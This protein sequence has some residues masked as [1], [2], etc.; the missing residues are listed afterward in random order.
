MRVHMVACHDSI[1]FILKFTLLII[2]MALKFNSVDCVKG[3]Q[4]YYNLKKLKRLLIL[5]LKL[6][7]CVIVTENYNI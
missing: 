4:N 5:T 2:G 6:S 3:A 7:S 1:A